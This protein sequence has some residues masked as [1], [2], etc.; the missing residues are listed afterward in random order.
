MGEIQQDLLGLFS[1][2]SRHNTIG[3]F[4]P[5]FLYS[6]GSCNSNDAK[7]CPCCARETNTREKDLYNVELLGRI[8]SHFKLLDA[9]VLEKVDISSRCKMFQQLLEY[10]IRN[11][12][13][14][15]D[16]DYTLYT[17]LQEV[18][19]D[20]DVCQDGGKRKI[21]IENIPAL[22]EQSSI[23]ERLDATC[24]EIDIS[25]VDSAFMIAFYKDIRNFVKDAR[26]LLD[27]Y[28]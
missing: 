17:R 1:G 10:I 26:G 8:Y 25:R 2:C 6:S 20:R 18:Y 16:G 19:L 4:I 24:C 5:G 22:E 13:H 15:R 3:L 12:N 11:Y 9:T 21:Q 7:E 14:V 23:L 27:E 28:M